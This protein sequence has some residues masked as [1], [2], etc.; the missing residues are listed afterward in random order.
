MLM[1]DEPGGGRPS[2]FPPEDDDEPSFGADAGE[3]LQETKQSQTFPSD[4][5]PWP[6][7]VD[8]ADLLDEIYRVFKEHVIM[9]DHGYVACALW[10]PHT[11]CFKLFHTTPRLFIHSPTHACGK[12]TVLDLLEKQV[13]RPIASSDATG[14]AI[15]RLIEAWGPTL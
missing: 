11:F 3:E 10:V 15:V 14:A 2:F 1:P 5:E 7:P 4:V 8:G 6:I 12:S 13:H 9:G